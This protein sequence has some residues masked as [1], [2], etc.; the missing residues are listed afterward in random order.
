MKSLLISLA[1]LLP[2]QLYANSISS[3]PIPALCGKTSDVM[4]ELKPYQEKIVWTGY[5]KKHVLVVVWVNEVTRTYTVTKTDFANKITCVFSVGEVD[6][7][8]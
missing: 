3:V 7:K 5:E 8:L 1:L 4:L 2:T 6:A